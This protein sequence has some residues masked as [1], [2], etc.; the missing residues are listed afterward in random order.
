M[1]KT[2]KR[3]SCLGVWYLGGALLLFAYQ[4]R[5][6]DCSALSG[7][8]NTY[9]PVSNIAGSIVTIGA[10][11][12]AAATFAVGDHVVLLQMT[13]MPPVQTGSNMG[14]YELRTVT[15]VS[16]SSITL[17]SITNTYSFS[18]EKVQLVRA[19]NCATGTASA[20]VTAKAWDGTT[21][22]VVALKGGTLTLNANIDATG[23][24][25]SQAN[26][27]TT[28]V[29]TSLSTGQGSTDGRGSNAHATFG[30]FGGGGL[31]GGGGTG[32]S[33]T[34]RGGVNGGSVYT[35]ANGYNQVAP[36][37]PGHY[38]AGVGGGGGI[39][40]GG[41]GGGGGAYVN[42]SGGGGG[43]GVSGGGSGG[44]AVISG[45]T[46]AGG[47]GGGEGGGG[48]D[49]GYV[50][51]PSDGDIGGGGGG[52]G[53]KGVGNGVNAACSDSCG[54][55]GGGGYGGGGGAASGWS[56][57]DDSYG[58]GGGGSWAGGGVSGKGGSNYPQTA[59]AGNNPV[60]IPITNINHYLN[61]TQPRLMMG[62]AGGNARCQTEGL[63]GGIVILEFNSVAGNNFGIKAN[64]ESKGLPPNCV[65][66]NLNFGTGGAGGGAG[67]QMSLNIQNF[68]S[69]TLLEAKGGKGGDANNAAT[70]HGGV[71]GAGGGGGGIWVYGSSTSTN[72]GGQT[73][74]IANTNLNSA[75]AIAGGLA[76]ADTNNPK[77]S[78]R[79]GTG[80]AGGNGF[81]VMSSDAPAWPACTPP[82][83]I[84]ASAIEA[85]C[86][87]DTANADGM[88][89]LS[90]AF[91][92][93]R[94]Q[95]STSAMF[96]PP[97]TPTAITAIPL[98]GK[99]ATTLPNPT[100]TTETYTV[101]IYD[102][103]DNTCYTDVNA[104]LNQVKCVLPT[105]S[106]SVQKLVS[107]APSGFVSPNFSL[108]VD[109]SDNSFDQT[110]TLANGASQT[111]ANIPVGTTCTVTEPS[112]ATA[113]TGYKY[114]AAV[115]NPSGAQTITAG[116]TASVSV[117]NPLNPLEV[118]IALSK[119]V[120]KTTVHWGAT[121]T[122]TLTATNNGADPASGVVVTDKLPSSLSYVS[123]SGG[124][125]DPFVGEWV[126]GSL[127][128]GET[129]TL[130]LTATVQ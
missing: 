63:G 94:Y 45:F 21:G 12:G 115:V 96:T 8:V 56:G 15:A 91:T 89:T 107:G 1:T 101:R 32:D 59:G 68:S 103:I 82:S 29:T 98:D 129:K 117:T 30:G 10:T 26:P 70:A 34:G 123:H 2:K 78:L 33:T 7:I 4:A 67:G 111:I 108:V 126:I 6:E 11:S 22:G 9:A 100:G 13:G 43:G 57:G 114:T 61:S 19:P 130:T 60:S 112:Q 14:K 58:G 46:A 23:S 83:S 24:G 110:L 44:S 53:V 106:L 80:G 36:W 81:I 27:P 113:P 122:Y 54:G 97:G 38:T 25:F 109:C 79:T 120:D 39:F 92:G 75:G 20:A 47:A 71:S 95:Y 74:T 16:G 42:R 85:T 18:T 3:M 84:T 48:S 5:G 31:G 37:T 93:L 121:V 50:L 128:V 28:T 49:G 90:G 64:G 40:G 69:S 66:S 51:T 87:G 88:L 73:V 118:D 76:G 52:G 77:N 99:V 105:G 124:S 41:G 62:G 125:Y 65:T 102:A 127:G 72:T 104:T 35:T 86:S 17:S 119:T 116:A 55:S